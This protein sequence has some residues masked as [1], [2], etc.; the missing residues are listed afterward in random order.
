MKS[1]KCLLLTLAFATPTFLF[2]QD[3]LTWQPPQSETTLV[4]MIYAQ[5]IDDGVFLLE[6]VVKDEFEDS[7]YA[8]RWEI[9]GVPAGG[10]QF[11]KAEKGNVIKLTVYRFPD[12][13]RATDSLDLG[14]KAE[15]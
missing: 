8:L 15:R 14:A 4:A 10:E 3:K 12:G 5:M 1:L 11:L 6:A 9:N 13:A 7:K 2:G